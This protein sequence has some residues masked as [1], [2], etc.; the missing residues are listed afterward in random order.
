MPAGLPAE[1][2]RFVR[3]YGADLA[4]WYQPKGLA[5]TPGS[6]HARLAILKEFEGEGLWRDHQAE[7]VA[8]LKSERISD[9]ESEW[10]DGGA[11][12]ARMLKQ[13]MAVLGLAWVD[14]K[15]QVEITPAGDAFLEAEDKAAILAG[16]VL[17]YQFWNPSVKSQTHQAVKLHPVPFLVRLMQAVDGTV[18]M[19][20]YNLFVA[21]ARA[22]SDV[23]KVA[24]QIDAFR[25]LSPE[26]QSEVVRQCRSYAI[27]GTRRG[28]IFQTIQL[29]RPYAYKMWTLS[30]LIGEGPDQSLRLRANALRGENRAFLDD[31]VANGAYIEFNNE[32]ELLA[33]MGDLRQKPT[34]SAALEIYVSRGDLPAAAAAK[35]S[36]GA[37]AGEL[38]GFR[39][40]MLDEKTLEDNIEANFS[41][42]GQNLGMNLELIGRQYATTVGPIDLLGRDRKSG[43][44]VVVE[45][46]RGRSADRVFGQ[47]SRYMGWVKKNLADGGSVEGVIVAAKIDDKLRSARD[48]H[49]TKVQLVEF[50]SKMSVAVV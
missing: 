15:D 31:Y 27:A 26:Q 40:M 41:S 24:E 37:S 19:V 20:E 1:W 8:R 32:K 30:S 44:Y 13:V 9:A 43:R 22:F 29:D 42:F 7:Y 10:A 12:L 47:L 3:Q 50:E 38:R 17:K 4:Y 36:L 39:R 21:K 23:D 28:S 46:K 25:A 14:P 6:V 45:L 33:W 48:A 35:K 16:Q 34:K 2:K 11:P 5:V 18:S 49:D